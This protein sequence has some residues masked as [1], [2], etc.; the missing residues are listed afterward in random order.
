MMLEISEDRLIK[1]SWGTFGV[2]GSAL[3]GF[4]FW[5][6]ALHSTALANS[7]TLEER[8]GIFIEISKSL[9]NIDKRLSTIEGYLKAKEINKTGE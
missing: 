1:I 5:L 8:S 2:L 6:S 4:V 9:N 3:V 7:K